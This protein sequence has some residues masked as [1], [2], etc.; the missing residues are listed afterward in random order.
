LTR[1][2]RWHGERGKKANSSTCLVVLF[3]GMWRG[4]ESERDSELG[5]DEEKGKRSLSVALPI[6][7]KGKNQMKSKR[8]NLVHQKKVN[9]GKIAKS[10]GV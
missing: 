4:G 7:P 6:S 2:R 3:K 9:T 8:T 5:T 10:R 1:G